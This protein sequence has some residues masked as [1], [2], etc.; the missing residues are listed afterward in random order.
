MAEQAVV[1][2]LNAVFAEW[3]SALER[4]A[5]VR[6]ESGLVPTIG[7]TPAAKADAF[8]AQFGCTAIGFNWEM[9]DPSADLAAPRSARATVREAVAMDMRDPRAM[10]LGPDA[11]LAF[12]DALL[13]AFDPKQC[14]ALTNHLN[15]LWFPI[16]GARDEWSFAI[17]DE[18]AIA[19]LIL[20]AKD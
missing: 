6:F 19:L 10:W 7:L 4:R 3:R 8:S 17:M 14:T 11:A 2:R 15:G 12:A 16:S 9:M 13:G 1:A 5:L 20:A 18:R